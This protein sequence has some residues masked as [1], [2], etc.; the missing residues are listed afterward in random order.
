[1]V[2]SAS[3]AEALTVMLAGAVKVAPSAGAVSETAGGWFV[4]DHLA[5]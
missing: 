2:P 3:L 5:R 4:E 1:M